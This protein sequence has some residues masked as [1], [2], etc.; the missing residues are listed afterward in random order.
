MN[1]STV[2]SQLEPQIFAE[3]NPVPS[4]KRGLAATWVLVDGKLTCKWFPVH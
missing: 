2:Q 3:L 1:T 4:R